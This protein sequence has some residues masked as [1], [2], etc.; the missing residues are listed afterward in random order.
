MNEIFVNSTKYEFISITLGL[1]VLLIE[2]D[3][4]PKIV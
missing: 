2:L 1:V 3:A 4:E